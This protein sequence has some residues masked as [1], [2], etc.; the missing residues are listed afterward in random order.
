MHAGSA[1]TLADGRRRSDTALELLQAQRPSA[2]PRVLLDRAGRYDADGAF[3]DAEAAG[4]WSVWRE[5]MSTSPR[6]IIRIVS[7]SRLRGRGGAG[8]P[9]GDKWRT[10][11][12]QTA[13]Q[14]YVVANG[15]EA[16]P[17]ALLDRTLMEL[18]PHAVVEGVAL[19]AYAVG[20]TKAYVVVKSTYRTAVRRLENAIRGAEQ[21]GYIGIDA[22]GEGFDLQIELV[23][24]QG[25]AVLGEETTLLY[26]LMGK[27]PLPE[28]RPPYPAV[29]GLWERPTV[30]NN[31]ETLAAVPWIIANG[32]AAFAKIGAAESPGTTLVQL[33]GAVAHPGVVEVPLGTPLREIVEGDGG[34]VARGNLK[35][36]LVGG[37][38]GGFLP[39]DG[40]D[41]PLTFDALEAAGAGMGSGTILVV[42][43]SACIVDVATLMT[44]FM[45][46]EACG[47]T[48]PC[49]IGLKRLTEI[50]E[51]FTSGLTRPTDL[52]VLRDLCADV[53][54]SAL[55]GHEYAA[56]NPLLSGMRYFPQ[57]F[58]DH[59]ARGTCPAGVCR[60]L[61]VAAA[62]A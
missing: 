8:F 43:D 11:H 18:D 46:D 30:V 42:D 12:N 29:Q 49:R 14:K 57:E 35:A 45:N 27:K 1:G 48:I 28:Q 53:R 31:V 6:A 47:K 41:I 3:A 39:A 55:C 38:P 54:D 44:R 26:A 33:S 9:T 19:A 34:G 5:V 61:S 23:E 52:T 20:A 62:L 37:A 51:R 58:E 56:T 2:W 10:C 17:G 24:L 59:I 13:D 4:A 25:A 32:S 21:A 22:L 7:E 50:G 36:L 40:L 15:Y 16:D 60:R